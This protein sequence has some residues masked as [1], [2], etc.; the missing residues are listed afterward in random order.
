MHG[1]T[2][3]E[4]LLDVC[5]G[6]SCFE[7]VARTGI[8]LSVWEEVVGPGGVVGT[9]GAVGGVGG[10]RARVFMIQV[11]FRSFCCSDVFWWWWLGLDVG[12]TFVTDEI[13]G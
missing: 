3:G 1:K 6:E 2:K 5:L 7:R 12:L 11:R 8:A 13:R 10:T 4:V 9:V